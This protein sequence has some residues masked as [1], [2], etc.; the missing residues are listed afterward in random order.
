MATPQAGVV[1]IFSR[2]MIRR[3]QWRHS[4]QRRVTSLAFPAAG[5]GHGQ[6]PGVEVPAAACERGETEVARCTRRG[7]NNCSSVWNAIPG[8]GVQIGLRTVG[9][10]IRFLIMSPK[11][12]D[13]TSFSIYLPRDNAARLQA[14]ADGLGMSRSAFVAALLDAPPSGLTALALD[15]KHRGGGAG[16]VRAAAWGAVATGFASG[17]L[18]ATLSPDLWSDRRK[19]AG[20]L[21]WAS[22][23]P[24]QAL[25][26]YIEWIAQIERTRRDEMAASAAPLEP[27]ARER[28][29]SQMAPDDILDELSREGLS[30]NARRELVGALM[31]AAGKRAGADAQARVGELLSIGDALIDNAPDAIV[32]AR[33]WIVDNILTEKT[34][35]N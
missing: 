22:Q 16:A 21:A 26:Y 2:V 15:A 30:R 7:E 29:I 17:Q 4:R 20:L 8:T 28:M 25:N 9:R 1:P 13:S 11:K 10:V 34:Q 18:A 5:A 33:A 35:E 14:A 19:V 6:L 3:P 24:E 31:I 23:N 12:D 32:A 27:S